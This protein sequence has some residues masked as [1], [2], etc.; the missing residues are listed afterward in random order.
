MCACVGEGERERALP[1]KSAPE[2]TIVEGI[3]RGEGCMVAED[4]ELSLISHMQA[5]IMIPRGK[6]GLTR[7]AM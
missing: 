6:Y 1:W 4:G 7:T 2:H 3:Q 5:E